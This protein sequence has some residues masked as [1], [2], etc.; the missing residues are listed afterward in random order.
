MMLKMMRA[1][2]HRAVV[3]Q[4]DLHYEGS[5][6]LDGDPAAPERPPARRSAA[7]LEP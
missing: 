3:T 6:G 7:R 2:I 5:I 4:A 1:K